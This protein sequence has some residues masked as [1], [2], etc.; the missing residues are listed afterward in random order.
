M[1]GQDFFLCLYQGRNFIYF[2]CANCNCSFKAIH[3]DLLLL[4]FGKLKKQGSKM[5]ST[6]TQDI[7]IF[8][9][10]EEKRIITMDWSCGQ[11]LPS[12]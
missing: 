10:K 2:K 1:I 5:E 12:A 4:I 8:K 9:K 11:P 7:Y 6:R 3:S